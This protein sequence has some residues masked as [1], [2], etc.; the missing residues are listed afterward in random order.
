[1]ARR[2]HVRPFATLFC[3]LLLAPAAGPG[4]AAVL[5]AQDRPLK[6]MVLTGQNA[7]I[8]QNALGV[9]HSCTI[10]AHNL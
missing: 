10:R 6:A 2:L 3:L 9:S 5:N 7:T 4:P 8:E 1:M